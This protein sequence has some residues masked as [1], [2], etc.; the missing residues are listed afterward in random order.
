MEGFGFQ[1]GLLGGSWVVIIGV[2]SWVTVII[3]HIR[4]LISP[5]ITNHEPP[6]RVQ[7][8]GCCLKALLR[9]LEQP[10]Q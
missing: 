2:V 6:S 10:E 7:G 3:T 9:L 4:G 1:W 8:S 5:L